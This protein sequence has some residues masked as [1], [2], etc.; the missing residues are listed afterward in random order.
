MNGLAEV[1]VQAA[2]TQYEP[3]SSVG[4]KL[5]C[6]WL[7]LLGAAL[8]IIGLLCTMYRPDMGANSF[9]IML[10]G[11]FFTA[12]G[13]IYGKRKLRGDIA[14]V[15]VG[16]QPMQQQFMQQ[17]QELGVPMQQLAQTMQAQQTQ[18]PQQITS[19]PVQPQPL[20]P[21][22]PQPAAKPAAEPRSLTPAEGKMLK[23]FVCPGCGAENEMGD[24]YCY[25]C[26]FNLEQVRLKVRKTKTARRKARAKPRVARPAKAMPAPKPEA[27][28]PAPRPKKTARAKITY[29]GA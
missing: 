29:E 20:Q 13:S 17:L 7:F 27:K 2:Q 3:P 24:K 23:I 10:M 15:P 14:V 25:R 9:I 26:G 11:L 16:Q 22:Q 12:A 5:K 8:A 19:V 6:I 18:P 28:K 4:F 21:A 1:P